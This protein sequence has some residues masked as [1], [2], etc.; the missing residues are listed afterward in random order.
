MTKEQQHVPIGQNVQSLHVLSTDSNEL[1][2]SSATVVERLATSVGVRQQAAS[3]TA[4]ASDRPLSV[5]QVGNAQNA[6]AGKGIDVCDF[7]GSDSDED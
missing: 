2:S 3:P 1:G 5:A 7:A 6:F 4:M